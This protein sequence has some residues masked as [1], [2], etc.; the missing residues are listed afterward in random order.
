VLDR[1]TAE[2]DNA[3]ALAGCTTLADI[4]PDLLAPAPR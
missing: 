4:T 1:L 3:M 2:L